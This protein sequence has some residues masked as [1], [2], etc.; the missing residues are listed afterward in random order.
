MVLGLR[1]LSV[2]SE[3]DGRICKVYNAT[4]ALR[5]R[6][7][8]KAVVGRQEM[9]VILLRIVRYDARVVVPE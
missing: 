4:N 9:T 8:C 2:P 7:T 6:I 3:V 5:L 1:L